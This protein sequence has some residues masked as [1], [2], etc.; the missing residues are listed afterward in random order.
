MNI[1]FTSFRKILNKK[2]K[3]WEECQDEFNQLINDFGEVDK[4]TAD[5]IRKRWEEHANGD[6]SARSKASEPIVEAA[7]K[8]HENESLDAVLRKLYIVFYEPFPWTSYNL[9]K[10]QNSIIESS[11]S[12]L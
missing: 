4:P 5:L 3:K 12:S 1:V 7:K 11:T 8:Y 10:F 9:S 6:E 2:I